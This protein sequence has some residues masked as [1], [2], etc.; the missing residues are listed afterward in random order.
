MSMSKTPDTFYRIYGSYKSVCLIPLGTGTGVSQD[1]DGSYYY[2]YEDGDSYRGGKVIRETV[3]PS[4]AAAWEKVKADLRAEIAE[5]EK[6]L[7]AVILAW[8]KD[9]MVAKAPL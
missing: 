3:Y 8:S 4:K 2:E 7:D 5:R 9:E 6:L 1:A